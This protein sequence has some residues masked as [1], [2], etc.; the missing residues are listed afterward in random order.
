M[1]STIDSTSNYMK[2]GAQSLSSFTGEES[3][4]PMMDN[5]RAWGELTQKQV[6][7]AKMAMTDTMESF[8]NITDPQAAF[9]LMQE[10][11]KKAMTM[12]AENMREAMALSVSQF[13]LG[14]DKIE[15]NH[16]APK[17]FA[18]VAKNLKTAASDVEEAV[19]SSLKNGTDALKKTRAS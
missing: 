11:L 2:Q 12:A 15:K 14:V 10:S 5:L 17:V 9:A 18:P 16:P 19:D 6:Q 4:Q 1:N 8:K 13:S 7:D 3:I